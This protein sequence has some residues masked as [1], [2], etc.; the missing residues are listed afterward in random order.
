MEHS[1]G[2]CPCSHCHPY[3]GCSYAKGAIRASQPRSRSNWT[4]EWDGQW[5]TKP[6]KESKPRKPHEN[7]HTTKSFSGNIS[8]F[9]LPWSYRVGFPPPLL[10]GIGIS[11]QGMRST[12]AKQCTFPSMI[13][14]QGRGKL[15]LKRL[16]MT[17]GSTKSS[18]MNAVCNAL[19]LEPS[20][21]LHTLLST[22]M[23]KKE[24]S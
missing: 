17:E 8:P 3:K 11:M 15:P 4:E 24:A 19:A 7:Y 5:K 12:A 22:T 9:F 14:R 16:L 10:L 21:S 2:G 6:T 23:G 1:S 18:T 13:S 20:V